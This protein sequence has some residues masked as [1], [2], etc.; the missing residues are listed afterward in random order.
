M[1]M[2]IVLHV[3]ARHQQLAIADGMILLKVLNLSS[4]NTIQGNADYGTM[5]IWYMNIPSHISSNI[6]K[7]DV[8][9]IPFPHKSV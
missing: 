9:K 5:Q 4:L 6:H 3:V 2:K 1:M 8:G 7:N